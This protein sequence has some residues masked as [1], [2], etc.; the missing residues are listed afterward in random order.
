MPLE[1]LGRSEGT[2]HCDSAHGVGRRDHGFRGRNQECSMRNWV[3]S[4]GRDRCHKWPCLTCDRNISENQTM[5]ARPNMQSKWSFSAPRFSNIS[6]SIL[7][8][9]KPKG[10]LFP[11]LES[12][13]PHS[14]ADSPFLR[15]TQDWGLFFGGGGV[16][17]SR[18]HPTKQWMRF[19]KSPKVRPPELVLRGL[20]GAYALPPHL[21]PDPP[22]LYMPIQE[23]AAHL[24]HRH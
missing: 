2:L 9:C 24:P 4:E 23:E 1:R 14:C 6:M 19:E 13:A 20:I 8:F 5:L 10:Q 22:S 11:A 12:E 18:S 21:P 3:S 16:Q 7:I 15:A 17:E